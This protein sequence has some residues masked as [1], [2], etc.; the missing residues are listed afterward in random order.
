[1]TLRYEDCKPLAKPAKPGYKFRKW[2][3]GAAFVAA[4]ILTSPFS[5]PTK[6]TAAE[7]AAIES[8]QT[9]P[10]AEE[11]AKQ[12]EDAQLAADGWFEVSNGI[13]AR[14]CGGR[15]CQKVS[16]IADRCKPMEVWAKDRAAGDVY[17]RGNFVTNGVVTGWTNDT[18]YLGKG[19][20]GIL[21]FNIFQD[22]DSFELTHFKA[23]G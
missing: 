5:E 19:Q 15:E 3:L 2:H 14:W 22:Y 13:Y 9:G 1:M 7:P 11:L 6:T 10:T 18:L 8:V 12:Q 16:C 20:R 17:A 23:R 4:I 21:K